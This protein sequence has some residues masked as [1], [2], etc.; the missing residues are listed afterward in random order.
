VL[1][2]VELGIPIQGLKEFARRRTAK[3]VT[4]PGQVKYS[5]NLNL[6]DEIMF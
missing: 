2:F 5:L 3:A 6:I 1:A 4:T